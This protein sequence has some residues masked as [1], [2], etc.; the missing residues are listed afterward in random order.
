MINKLS[1]K[2]GTFVNLVYNGG[3]KPGQTRLIQVDQCDNVRN[4]LIGQENGAYR[5]FKYN[6]IVYVAP[7]K[8]PTFKKT[9]VKLKN[10]PKKKAT[11]TINKSNLTEST[12]IEW[13]GDIGNHNI[14]RFYYDGEITIN[15]IRD[16]KGRIF[17]AIRKA[18]KS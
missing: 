12:A 10:V 6:K 7:T 14:V 15:G 18:V 8:Y 2:H 17:N 13:Y 5:S 3:S 11:F 9:Q 1:F 4:L 16:T